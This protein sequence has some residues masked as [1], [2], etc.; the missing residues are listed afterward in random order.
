MPA[1]SYLGNWN[2]AKVYIAQNPNKLKKTRL[3]NGL[4]SGKGDGERIQNF[5]RR[6]FFLI[7]ANNL[8]EWLSARMQFYGTLLSGTERTGRFIFGERFYLQYLR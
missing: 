8:M 3:W 6:P 7:T 2:F 5:T 4:K 1:I